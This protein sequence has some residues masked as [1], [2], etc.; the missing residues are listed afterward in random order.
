M[1]GAPLY[2][3]KLHEATPAEMAEARRLVLALCDEFNA[4]MDAR[5]GPGMWD[6]MTPAER[7]C[8]YAEN[9]IGGWLYVANEAGAG[10][11][12]L[13]DV[14]RQVKQKILRNAQPMP[15]CLRLDAGDGVAM[16]ERKP[17]AA[18][19]PGLEV[20]HYTDVDNIMRGNA[21]LSPSERGASDPDTTSC[22]LPIYPQ[23]SDMPCDP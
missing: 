11:H 23:P 13:D 6:E 5:V 1:I 2:Q 8:M 4:L 12:S 10:R 18:A 15:K 9:D 3:P 16:I 7:A 21:D 20:T 19:T 22:T 17:V 14:I